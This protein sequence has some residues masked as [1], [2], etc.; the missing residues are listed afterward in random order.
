MNCIRM[1]RP[2]PKL[3][4]PKRVAAY[5]RVS[6]D[7]DAMLHSLSAQISYYQRLIQNHKGWTF[8]GVYADNAITG[9]KTSRENFQKLLTQCRE[10]NI[11]LIITKSV[12]RFSRNTVALLEIVRE[13]IG[14]AHV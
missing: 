7:N 6:A 5:A 1:I 2:L 4:K 8:A 14:R 9:T 3:T 12:S 13:Q 10:G 11:D